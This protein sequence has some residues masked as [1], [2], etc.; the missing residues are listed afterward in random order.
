MVK[1]AL[2]LSSTRAYETAMSGPTMVF[3]VD[4][5]TCN[6]CKAA[7]ESAIQKV[8]G[9]SEAI[10]ELQRGEAQVRGDADPGD[11]VRAIEEEGYDASLL[12]GKTN[13]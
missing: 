11:I 8:P 13:G 5:M 10:V 7:V 6:H 12:P 3:R 4:G 1:I 9:V 2:I